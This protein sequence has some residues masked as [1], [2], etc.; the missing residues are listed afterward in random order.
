[1]LK[2]S[3]VVLSATFLATTFAASQAQ[4]A[5]SDIYLEY[6]DTYTD[7]S[8]NVQTISSGQI[9]MTTSLVNGTEYSST[10][11]PPIQ[12]GNGDTLSLQAQASDNPA[13]LGDEAI[14]VS[15]NGNSNIAIWISVT[16]FTAP[17]TDSSL[18]ATMSGSLQ[19][20]GAA[21]SADVSLTGYEGNNSTLFGTSGPSVTTGPQSYSN[22]GVGTNVSFSMPTVS[23]AAS[24]F[25][26]PYTLTDVVDVVFGSSG[27]KAQLQFTSDLTAATP[28]P[29]STVLF[30]T[31]LAGVGIV[32]RKRFAARS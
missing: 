9:D 12:I 16:G 15:S 31:L 23:S 28:E 25:V 22:P 7:A 14:T 13:A 17:T 10:G 1:M 24:T 18:I 26:S 5:L 11:T 2:F 29:A 30:G 32:T 8:N 4:A 6:T 20:T 27:G 19:N 3:G 21:Y